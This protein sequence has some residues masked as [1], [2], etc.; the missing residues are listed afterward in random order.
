MFHYLSLP[1]PCLSWDGGVEVLKALN[2]KTWIPVENS[3]ML[4]APQMLALRFNID[5]GLKR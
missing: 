1:H 2:L 3:F 4:S 5:Q